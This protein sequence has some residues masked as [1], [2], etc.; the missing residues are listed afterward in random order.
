M[1]GHHVC[2]LVNCTIIV[3]EIVYASFID[4]KKSIIGKNG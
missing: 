3:V 1:P 2:C 4:L